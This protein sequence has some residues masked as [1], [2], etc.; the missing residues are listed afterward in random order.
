MAYLFLA[1]VACAIGHHFHYASLDGTAVD[2]EVS[3]QWAIRIGTGLAFLA[4]TCLTASVGVAYTQRLWVTVKK[5]PISLGNLD[6]V[7]S[8]TTDPLS[9]LSFEVLFSAKMLCLLAASMW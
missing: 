6:N 7:F 2:T 8:L 4:K 1:G 3:Q 9:F 5:K